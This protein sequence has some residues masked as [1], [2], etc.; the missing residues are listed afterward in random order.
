MLR[1]CKVLP[2]KRQNRNTGEYT[3]KRIHGILALMVLVMLASCMFFNT[4]AYC[5]KKNKD[6]TTVSDNTAENSEGAAGADT[7][8]TEEQNGDETTADGEA[9]SDKET[10]AD[11]LTGKNAETVSGDEIADDA[12]SGNKAYTKKQ[13][14]WLD[15]VM[16]DT[17]KYIPVYAG[18]GDGTDIIG[19]MYENSVATVKKVGKK[20]TKVKSGAIKGY[21]LNDDCIYGID[22]LK[23][24]KQLKKEKTRLTLGGIYT[25]L[26]EFD[27]ED[28]N[29]LGAIIY[30]EGGY[31]IY[32]GQ[33]AV[34]AV[35]MNRLESSLFPDTLDGV[36]YQKYQFG[37]ASSG[38][39]EKT[40][41]EEIKESCLEAAEDAFYG[42]D[43]TNGAFYFRRVG[44]TDGIEI[45]NHVFF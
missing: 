44:Y 1:V 34:G 11:D 16:A 22:A 36:I 14:K 43:P 7:A 10:P 40:L 29:L 42:V 4:D 3:V 12:V 27:E 45:G 5:A 35:V 33:V 13:K 21:I 20:F 41:A 37:P 28:R 25:P 15:K 2:D 31:E 32:E 19:R 23:H 38:L 18:P 26:I 6:K 8:K 30:C 9:T 17:D 39:L 24:K